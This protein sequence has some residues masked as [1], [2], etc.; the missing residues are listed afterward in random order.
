M[1]LLQRRKELILI[2]LMDANIR[3]TTAKD[4]H[5]AFFDRISV[6]I[7]DFV[8]HNE[9]ANLGQAFVVPR[10]YRDFQTFLFERANQPVYITVVVNDVPSKDNEIYFF[11]SAFFR[12]LPDERPIAMYVAESQNFH[13]WLK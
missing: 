13:Q 1:G 10:Q 7:L 12:H 9:E 5:I 4:T 3:I 8:L 2:K 6:K 11:L